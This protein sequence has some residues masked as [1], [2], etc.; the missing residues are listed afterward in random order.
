MLKGVLLGSVS[1]LALSGLLVVAV[2]LLAPPPKSPVDRPVAAQPSAP[3]LRDQAEVAPRK[4]DPLPARETPPATAGEVATPEDTAPTVEIVPIAPAAPEAEPETEMADAPPAPAPVEREVEDAGTEVAAAVPLP[5]GSEFNRPPEDVAIVAPRTED[6]PRAVP[7]TDRGRPDLS[8]AEAPAP[9][10]ASA[11]QPQAGQIAG[12]G[13]APQ[14]GV[15]PI[16]PARPEEGAPRTFGEVG[17]IQDIEVTEELEEDG[18]RVVVTT[19]VPSAPAPAT[20]PE[21]EPETEVATDTAPSAEAETEA[22]AEPAIAEVSTEEDAADAEDV[23][24][25]EDAVPDVD[26]PDASSDEDIAG[27]TT[28]QE[29]AQAEPRRSAPISL[30]EDADVVVPPEE[31][32]APEVEEEAEPIMP[33]R[34]VLDSERAVE[35]EDAT[36]A[37]ADAEPAQPRPVLETQAATFEN[38]A[39]LPRLS[40]VLIHDP[41]LGVDIQSL[42]A[43]EFPVTFA[44]DPT[45]PGAEAAAKAYRA[46]GHE[47]VLRGE[48]L[49]PGG[50]AQDIEVAFTAARAAVPQALGVLDTPEGG[51]ARDRDALDALL[52]PLS[53]AGMGF[54]AYPEGLNSGVTR[55]RREGVSATTLYRE[56]DAEDERAPVITRYL[57]RATFEAVQDG[58]AV[59]V[60]RTSPETITA[61]YSWRL[62]ARAET[63]APAPLS[64]VL[65]DGDG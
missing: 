28:E 4:P 46:A 18:R 43:L 17:S 41:D 12:F 48:A 3:V 15:A 5:S 52:R 35:A 36:E 45:L 11:T 23:A 10:T 37:V 39:D 50:S 54:V 27:S 13:A 16:L 34:L 56:L 20:E 62:G 51:F 30:V 25:A 29:V 40:I 33:R 59:V 42:A 24:G 49:S 2:S 47:V 14:V 8:V 65:R 61:L 55:A 7:L 1:G 6:A 53:E 44:L 64:T 63:V 60:G 57:D 31:E 26:A 38:T 58:A 22:P 21:A 32:R 9:E 19:T